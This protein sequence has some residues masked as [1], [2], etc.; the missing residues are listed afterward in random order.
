MYLNIL[1]H[2]SIGLPFGYT[3]SID[4]P[5]E[6]NEKGQVSQMEKKSTQVCNH[7]PEAKHSSVSVSTERWFWSSNAKDI[8]TLY[9]IF[10]LFSGLIGT[11][12]SVLIRLELSGPGV[13]FIADNQLYNS[14]ITANVIVMI[15]SI[16]MPAMRGGFDNFFLPLSS[17]VSTEPQAFVSLP[18]QSSI[19]LGIFTPQIFIIQ[20]VFF[21]FKARLS[22]SYL[23]LLIKGSIKFRLIISFAFI[24]LIY[25]DVNHDTARSCVLLGIGGY[26]VYMLRNVKANLL[27]WLYTLTSLSL[28][29]LI[30]IT[31]WWL[32]GLAIPI[33]LPILAPKILLYLSIIET[34]FLESYSLSM[35]PDGGSDPGIAGS[36][37]AAGG[38]GGAGGSGPGGLAD[39]SGSSDD[40]NTPGPFYTKYSPWTTDKN[41]RFEKANSNLDHVKDAKSFKASADSVP[42]YTGNDKKK[43][44]WEAKT[45]KKRV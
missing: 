7:R 9:L 36:A 28:A 18:L 20:K 13:Q 6:Y 41:T 33:I 24:L 30:I 21:D 35:N 11:A 39:L 1:I 23:S 10:A 17:V 45:Y 5:P 43:I 44:Y 19:T 14:V 25:C 26:Y 12:F 8:G 29:L 38:P 40:D 27:S 15:F 22:F 37:G 32:F 31:F 4:H 2:I 3:L 16:V 34:S 42:V